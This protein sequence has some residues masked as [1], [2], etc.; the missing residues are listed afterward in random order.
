MAHR[1]WIPPQ[2][3][4]AEL[5]AGAGAGA[6]GRV[7]AP[8]ARQV[9]RSGLQSLFRGSEATGDEP[10]ARRG[11]AGW[12]GPESV[13]WQVH[14]DAS[15]FVAGIAALA[16]QSLHPLVMAGVADHSDFGRDPIGRLRRTASF[17]GVTAYGTSA[18]AAEACAAVRAVHD[19]I[20]GQAPDGRPYAAND[21]DL[22]DWVHVTEF[23][24][25]AAAHR[26][27]GAN[28][29]DLDE[30]DRYV[31]E[32]ARVAVELGDPSPPRSWAQL[33]EHL[34]RHRPMTAVGGQARAAWR[35]LEDPPLPGPVRAAWPVLFRGA[36]ACLPPWATELWGVSRPTTAERAACRVAVRSLGAVL[37]TSPGLADATDRAVAVAS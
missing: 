14:A 11:D 32:V 37:G 27:Y 3:T 33:D 2:P 12:F 10:S 21:P 6:A 19:R 5:V 36:M 15:M 16:L 9:L 28:P 1:P 7:V 34:E 29:M 20:V 23:G 25:F 26:R 35:F 18:Q 13:T 17:V 4:P 30:L 31:D 24:T 8:V 22:L